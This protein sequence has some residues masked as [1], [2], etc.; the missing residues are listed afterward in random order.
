MALANTTKVLKINTL[1]LRETIFL[2]QWPAWY[3]RCHEIS[4]RKL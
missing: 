3:V 4:A 2:A 1:G